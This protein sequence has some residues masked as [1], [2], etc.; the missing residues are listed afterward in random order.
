MVGESAL[1]VITLASFVEGLLT[2]LIVATARTLVGKLVD[3]LIGL[4][5]GNPD[6]YFLLVL[7][8]WLVF[9]IVQLCWRPGLLLLPELLCLISHLEVC[10]KI[11][12][13][14]WTEDSW[15]E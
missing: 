8:A 13:A 12:L 15:K 14:W 5:V 9:W 4:L 10:S 6:S 2:I 3:N 7:E 1:I 11:W